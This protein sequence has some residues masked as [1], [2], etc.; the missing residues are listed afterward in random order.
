[1]NYSKK[2]KLLINELGQISLIEINLEKGREAAEK[3]LA[4]LEL[5]NKHLQNS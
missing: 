2:I 4:E 1:M 3:F 5:P